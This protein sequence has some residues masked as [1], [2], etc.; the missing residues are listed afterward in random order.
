MTHGEFL[1]G[2]R[3]F[4]EDALKRYNELPDE[5]DELYKRY[6]VKV[7]LGEDSAV[8]DTVDAGERISKSIADAT[9]IVFDAV[10]GASG[11]SAKKSSIRVLQP[12]E[13]GNDV[14]ES[15]IV[16]SGDDKIAALIHAHSKKVVLIDVP[17]GADE[18][19]N[20]LFF[21]VDEQ[22]PVQV[23]I[24]AGE[25]S[26]LTLLE[27]YA[28]E[29]VAQ[30]Y[31]G[32]LHEVSAGRYSNVEIDIIHNENESTSVAGFSKCRS[33]EG[34]TIRFNQVF[35]GAP[36]T[37]AKSDLEAYGYSSSVHGTE[38][39]IGSK[40]QKF[41]IGSHITNSAKASVAELESKAVL[42]GKSY[43]L[44]KGLAKIRSGAKESKSF[45]KESGLLV[46]PQAHID[47][48]PSMS[49]DDSD[50]KATHSSATA[51]IDEEALFYM[52][53]KGLDIGHAKKL[54]VESYMSKAIDRIKNPAVREVVTHMLIEK[55][56]TGSFG[57]VPKPRQ[58]D[59]W[60]TRNIDEGDL[61][62]GH[63]KYR[64]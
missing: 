23:I 9:G 1:D 27:W 50:V 53:T 51:P 16:H 39:A 55:L 21:A 4:V 29:G 10:V 47:S 45:L 35:N 64:S 14:L 19:M 63:Y 62:E 32:P 6:F 52:M 46:D 5:K 26:K 38:I 30:K 7:P 12:Q 42:T 11:A 57:T 61:F 18:T 22:L 60:M 20:I 33:D 48:I 24:K 31:I 13:L 37:K 36:F 15:K 44:F 40:E 28:S 25:N 3:L 58:T 49:V 41:D 17:D 56:E 59:I 54:V 8:K 2:Y 34:A 43:C